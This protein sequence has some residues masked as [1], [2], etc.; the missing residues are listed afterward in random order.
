MDNIAQKI[1]SFNQNMKSN[2]EQFEKSLENAAI[3]FIEKI[4]TCCLEQIAAYQETLTKGAKEITDNN[5][6]KFYVT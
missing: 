6:G 3:T 2:C 5:G 1:D 4:K